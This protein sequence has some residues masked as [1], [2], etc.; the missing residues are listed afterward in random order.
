MIKFDDDFLSSVGLAAL[1]PRGKIDLLRQ[2]YE[3]LELRVGERLVSFMTEDQLSEFEA[4]IVDGDNDGARAWL[5][6]SLPR[7]RE[8]VRFEMEDLTVEVRANAER[9]L[10]MDAG[11]VESP[12]S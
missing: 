12:T 1:S 4:L 10:A 11:H 2:V 7:Y 9:I 8:V 5:E 6:E 3:T